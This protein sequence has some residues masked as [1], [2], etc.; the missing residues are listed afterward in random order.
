MTSP[1]LTMS[2][3]RRMLRTFCVVG[4]AVSMFIPACGKKE[5]PPPPPPPPPPPVVLPDPVDVQAL[6]QELGADARVQIARNVNTSERELAEAVIRFANAWA[7]GD[8]RA[9]EGMLARSDRAI[10]DDL[11]ARGEWE[12]ETRKIEQVRIVFLTEDGRNMSAPAPDLSE[13][14]SAQDMERAM[15]SMPTEMR[16]MMRQMTGAMSQMGGDAMQN[17]QRQ[18][19]ENPDLI[20]TQLEQLRR[21][22]PEQAKMVESLLNQG[23][24]SEI[25]VSGPV[26]TIAL[27][28]PGAAYVL[29]WNLQGQPGNYR[30][31]SLNTVDRVRRRASEWDGQSGLAGAARAD[32]PAPETPAP[33]SEGRQEES[34]GGDQPF[35][36]PGQKSTPAGPVTIPGS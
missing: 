7:K 11:R 8:A 15:A 20:K 35:G 17:I 18:L 24:D 9:L 10:L 36:T 3:R 14:P 27:Q 31:S 16:E 21:S 13:M 2:R 19:A 5:E 25:Q 23:G 12:S 4:L 1:D 30:F 33:S 6:R 26:V 34:G 29:A 22:N 32:A 28:Q